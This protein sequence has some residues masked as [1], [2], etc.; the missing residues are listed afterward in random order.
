M[1]ECELTKPGKAE[2]QTTLIPDSAIFAIMY[3]ANKI[4]IRTQCVLAIGGLREMK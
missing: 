4:I 3:R 2:F 1:A